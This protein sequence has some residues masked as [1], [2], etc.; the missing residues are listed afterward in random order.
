MEKKKRLPFTA[1]LA[2]E[3]YGPVIRKMIIKWETAEDLEGLIQYRFPG[4]IAA[5][6][7]TDEYGRP[8][9]EGMYYTVYPVSGPDIEWNQAF[10]Y[11]M[12]IGRNLYRNLSMEGLKCVKTVCP[13]AEVFKK[14]VP[15]KG[16]KTEDGKEIKLR[17]RDYLPGPYQDRKE[18][19]RSRRET[20]PLIIWLHGQ[21]EGGQDPSIPLLGN[22]V[23]SLAQETVQMYFPKTGAAVLVPQCPTMWMDVDGKEHWNVDDLSSDGGSYYSKALEGLIRKYVQYHPEIDRNR[24]YIGGCSNGGYMTVKLLLEMPDFFAAA[25]PCCPA[26]HDAWMTEKRIRSLAKTPMWVVAAATDQTIPLRY[27]D[28]SPA[29]ADAMV[30]KL[31]EVSGEVIY[32][33]L[34]QVMGFDSKGLPYEYFGHWS[35]VPLLTDRITKEFDGE[36]IHLFEWMAAKHREKDHK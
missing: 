29:F 25:F 27:P 4:P 9:P 2:P 18:N 7:R 36:E 13:E 21:G 34:P 20:L 35:W 5:R 11:H 31:R 14:R 26:Y 3:D 23:T 24:I 15:F 19:R 1:V 28:G 22:R 12:D 8:D 10:Q 32:S 33:R 6:E 17:Y 30:E 16:L